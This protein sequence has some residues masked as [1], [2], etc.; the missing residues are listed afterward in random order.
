M[1]NKTLADRLELL[2]TQV[3]L[4]H[5]ENRD[6]RYSVRREVDDVYQKHAQAAILADLLALL[7]DV[8]NKPMPRLGKSGKYI[9][10][11]QSFQDGFMEAE[12]ELTNLIKQYAG[13]G[14]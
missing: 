9:K 1:T 2:H 12:A 6:C 14:E 10:S 8:G 13:K 11:S 4:N 7:R 5:N 3:S